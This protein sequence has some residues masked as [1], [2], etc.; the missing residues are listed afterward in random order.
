MAGDKGGLDGFIEVA[1]LNNLIYGVLIV[2][3]LILE[4]HGLAAVWFRIKKLVQD[5]AVQLLTITNR[6]GS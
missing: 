2:V 5:L 6:G 3:F 1:S 4:P